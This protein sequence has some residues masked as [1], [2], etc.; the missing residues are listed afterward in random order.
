M[1]KNLPKLDK[2][3]HASK[4]KVRSIDLPAS[5]RVNKYRNAATIKFV[6]N[7]YF[8]K[9]VLNLP[10]N[11]E[12]TLEIISQQLNNLYVRQTWDKKS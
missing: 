12:L 2:M 4:N 5:K 11:V 9:P 1:D 10:R 7:D 3:Q 6:N 8:L